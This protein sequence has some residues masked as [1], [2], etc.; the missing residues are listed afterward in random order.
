MAADL[1]RMVEGMRDNL[2]KI[3]LAQ[4]EA[5]W[6][7]PMIAVSK[8]LGGVFTLGQIKS[9]EHA[10]EWLRENL[11]NEVDNIVIGRM[12]VKQSTV[13]GA[14]GQPVVKEKAIMVMGRHI[15]SKRAYLSITPCIEHRDYRSDR[16][17]EKQ[18]KEFDPTLKGA[19]KTA[20]IVDEI[21]GQ[22]HYLQAKF[23][24]EQVY[25]SKKGHQFLVD[26]IIEMVYPTP[27]GTDDA[28]VENLNAP[29]VDRARGL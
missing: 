9:N 4:P 10:V 18:N 6:N 8:K 26:P 25:D 28:V 5:V 19:D 16:F 20:K 23:G 24:P 7:L 13:L 21:T 2:K 14:D 29:T 11:V 17:A 15:D 22:Q 3:Y 12:V 27:R 1:T